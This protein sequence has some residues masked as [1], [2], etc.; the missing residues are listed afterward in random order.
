MNMYAFSLKIGLFA[1]L[2]GIT[3]TAT[4]GKISGVSLKQQVQAAEHLT[5][6]PLLPRAAFLNA[7]RIKQVQLSPDG[8]YLIYQQVEGDDDSKIVSVWRYHID[9]GTRVKLFSYQQLERFIWTNNGNN[10][11]LETHDAIALANIEKSIPPV[12]ITKFDKTKHEGF[13]GFSHH[14]DNKILMRKWDAKQSEYYVEQVD[15]SGDSFELYRSAVMFNDFNVDQEGRPAYIRVYNQAKNNKGEQFIY[16]LQPN[17]KQKIFTCQWDDPCNIVSFDA[18]QQALILLTNAAH[19]L[20]HL[21]RIDAKGNHTIIHQDPEQY[22]D[23]TD[24]V[25]STKKPSIAVYN[26]DYFSNHAIETQ[27]IPHTKKLADFFPAQS[28]SI[29]IP[30][31][32]PPA[33]QLKQGN[34]LISN[35]TKSATTKYFIYN[36]KSQSV[37]PVLEDIIEQ[38]NA[39]LPMIPEQYLAP[40]FSLNYPN[41][42]QLTLQG[43]VTLPRGVNIQKAPLI[44][45]PHGGPWAKDDDGYNLLAQFLANRGYI[46]FQPNFRAS[47]G[48]GKQHHSGVRGDFGN[49][50]THWDIMDGIDYLLANN[51]G[52]KESLGIAGHSFGGYST[53]TALVFEPNK[54]KVGFAGAPPSHI[55]RSAQYYYRFQK[56][57]FGQ[58]QRYYMKHLVVDWD[59]EQAFKSLTAIQPETHQDQITAPLTIWAGQNDARVFITDVRNFAL[60]AQSQGKPITLVVDPNAGHS[61]NSLLGH[62]AYLFLLEASLGSVLKKPIE[63]IHKDKDKSLYRFFKK[64]SAINTNDFMSQFLH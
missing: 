46:V 57:K 14:S 58:L 42:D 45:L 12:I 7:S 60:K 39:S 53:L 51:V 61:A 30:Q 50:R 5:K 55:G 20:T 24:I 63:P 10:F 49:G 28:H 36:L 47:S 56:K 59:N 48:L 17:K 21:A 37:A 44:A 41:R 64:N 33:W 19:N 6:A 40:R 22:G 43:Y 13:L 2:F 38:A 25:F 8:Q 32:K 62:N 16:A 18:K 27:F 23:L 26:G 35:R 11:L 52:D 9:D 29:Q 15:F 1:L 54:F 34:W 4:A 31:N 3:L